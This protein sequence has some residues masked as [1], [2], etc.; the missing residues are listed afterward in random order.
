MIR[1][2]VKPDQVER[3]EELVRAVFA[4]LHEVQPAG[5]GYTALKLDDGVTFVHLVRNEAESGH[6][7]VRGLH[8]LK[9]FHAGIHDRCEEA[10]VRST[11]S[12]IGS[13]RPFEDA[14]Q[15]LSPS[16]GGPA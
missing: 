11:V 6:S 12:V 4:E 14:N 3:N 9:A 8:A 16:A 5:L 15:L 13:F 1:Y 10:P 7:P 2:K